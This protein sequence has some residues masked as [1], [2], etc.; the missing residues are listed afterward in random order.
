MKA[1]SIHLA[2]LALVLGAAACS[3]G[4]GKQS[5]PTTTSTALTT[6]T[7]TVDT[8]G[9]GVTGAQGSVSGSPVVA[10]LGA[11]P[12]TYPATSLTE[13]NVGVERLDT[14]LVPI[15]ATTARICQ[16]G[17]RYVTHHGGGVSL[18]VTPLVASGLLSSRATATLEQETNRLSKGVAGAPSCPD[19]PTGP[20]PATG[21]KFFYLTFAGESQKV[22]VE[23]NNGVC[24][25]G[26]A[27]NGD[28]I[29]V[30]TSAWLGDVA[31]YAAK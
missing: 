22:E 28:F 29:A 27:G 11:C 30:P 20:G 2:A 19:P 26:E 4:G 5:T 12:K 10:N 3:S 25:L 21:T 7:R 1:T 17:G 31:R 9:D 23:Q 18:V 24:S 14:K 8:G 16:Y 6:T 15:A 13:L